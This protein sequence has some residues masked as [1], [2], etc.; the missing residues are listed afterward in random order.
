MQPPLS[1][2]FSC[3]ISVSLSSSSYTFCSLI[4]ILQ[5]CSIA[6][7]WPPP[8]PCTSITCTPSIGCLYPTVSH[9]RCHLYLKL[10]YRYSLCRDSRLK[11]FFLAKAKVPESLLLLFSGFSCVQYFTCSLG[12]MPDIFSLSPE[13]TVLMVLEGECLTFLFPDRINAS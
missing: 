11:L 1:W 3:H 9:T 12:E 7:P 13:I 6:E 2:H 5:G 4:C 10:M 8:T